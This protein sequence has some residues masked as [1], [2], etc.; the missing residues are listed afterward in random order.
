MDTILLATMILLTPLT[1]I[2]AFIL[3]E[4]RAAGPSPEDIQALT[5]EQEAVSALNRIREI[6]LPP[7]GQ[8]P[9]EIGLANE[10]AS[11]RT[12]EEYR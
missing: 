5:P 11:L 7:E 10:S 4:S 3:S 6:L 1:G 9:V 8:S 2:W 12:A